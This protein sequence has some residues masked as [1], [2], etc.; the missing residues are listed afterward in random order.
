MF[1]CWLKVTLMSWELPDWS[2]MEC[3]GQSEMLG[4]CLRIRY[5]VFRTAEVARSLWESVLLVLDHWSKKRLDEVEC[6]T[7]SACELWRGC[8]HACSVASHVRL[9]ETYGPCT[10]DPQGILR[11]RMLEWVAT[12][13]SGFFW[14]RDGTHVSYIS[15]IGVSAHTQCLRPRAFLTVTV[16]GGTNKS[17]RSS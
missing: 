16:D 15:C 17:C 6:V 1:S 13:H 2:T 10:R 11:A 9:F 3:D 14:P 8:A 5:I 12:F 4:L 7:G